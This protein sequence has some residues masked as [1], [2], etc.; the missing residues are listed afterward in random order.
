MAGP[1]PQ[2]AQFNAELGNRLF[3]LIDSLVANGLNQVNRIG[4]TEEIPLYDPS[5]TLDTP[6]RNAGWGEVPAQVLG[7]GSGIVMDPTG[8]IGDIAR[9]GA[10]GFP[11]LMRL[12]GQLLDGGKFVDAVDVVGDVGRAGRRPGVRL[13]RSEGPQGAGPVRGDRMGEGLTSPSETYWSTDPIR[14]GGY[15]EIYNDLN[16]EM[17]NRS[18]VIEAEL[19]LDPNRVLDVTDDPAFRR[20]V[21]EQ[22]GA[23]SQFM[24]WAEEL[25]R[26]GDLDVATRG[27]ITSRIDDW[28]DGVIDSKQLL[29]ELRAEVGTDLV[30]EE[31]REQGLS[32]LIQYSEDNMEPGRW[33][34]EVI[35]FD[36]DTLRPQ[37][38]NSVDEFS[39]VLD[40]VEKLR[41]GGGR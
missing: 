31:L 20:S 10:V 6:F 16:P 12:A 41:G 7:A 13:Y 18:R 21:T 23:P 25:T 1:G 39:A 15:G 22:V 17:A 33:D 9:V 19:P 38:V 36:R 35:V 11:A 28:R 34:R 30:S 40:M 14:A 3:Q 32:G 8:A 2:S 24:N 29:E 4:G 5:M 27:R 26:R 37:N